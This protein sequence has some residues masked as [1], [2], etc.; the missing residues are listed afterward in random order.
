MSFVNK[1][2]F[3]NLKNNFSSTPFS[4]NYNYF[5]Y[6][7]NI[8]NKINVNKILNIML[9]REKELIDNNENNIKTDYDKKVL[10]VRYKFFNKKIFK[11]KHIVDLIGALKK[12]VYFYSKTLNEPIPKKLWIQMWCNILREN[13]SI[14]IHQHDGSEN[15]YLSG[16][17]C[18][19]A[20]NTKT[21]FVNPQIYFTKFN[22]D[23]SSEN[24]K[25]NLTIFPSTLPHYTDKVEKNELRVTVA[26]DVLTEKN[27]KKLL[28]DSGENNLFKEN[29]LEFKR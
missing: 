11:S 9:D 6:E 1:G 2:K 17:L 26:F 13:Q 3:I 27:K 12:N 7:N 19:Q 10:L 4:P 16:N 29:I 23:Y 14:E 8:C 15:S 24:K 25:G 21:H 20:N 28:W 18:L 22:S 5:I